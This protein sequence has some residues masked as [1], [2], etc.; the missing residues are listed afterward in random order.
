MQKELTFAFS[1]DRVDCRSDK[2]TPNKRITF[3]ELRD[4]I[5]NRTFCP[6]QYDELP[7]LAESLYIHGDESAKA[8]LLK[9]KKCSPWVLFGGYCPIGHAD[10]YLQ[11]N[12]CT[13]VDID[14]KTTDGQKKALN[15]LQKIKNLQPVDVL[16]AG[17]SPSTFG[18]K[19]LLATTATRIEE[20]KDAS[21]QAIAYL[22]KLLQIEEKFFDHLGASQPVFIPYE[23]TPGQHYWQ[24]DATKFDVCFLSPA[25]VSDPVPQFKPCLLY[26]SPS[27]RDGLLSRMPSSA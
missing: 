12:G 16:F 4:I 25:V 24:P 9:G 8:L 14:F 13:Q 11:Y 19:I 7:T 15:I 5:T 18:V 2:R 22:A 10:M 27:P 17:L 23:R 21:K 26:T 6:S 3:A 20:H 1:T